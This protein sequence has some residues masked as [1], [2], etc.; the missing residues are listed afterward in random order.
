MNGG[1]SAPSSLV[2]ALLTVR[3]CHAKWLPE[4]NG[5]LLSGKATWNWRESIVS[6]R[7]LTFTALLL[8]SVLGLPLAGRLRS[9]PMPLIAPPPYV[10]A[11]RTLNEA[12][13][14]LGEWLPPQE[15]EQVRTL[16]ER[17]MVLRYYR[18]LGQGIRNSWGLWSGGSG[19]SSQLCAMGMRDAEMMSV[20]VLQSFW[21]RVHS[22]PLRVEEQV[23]QMTEAEAKMISDWRA[24]H[25]GELAIRPSGCPV[26]DWIE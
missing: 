4:A 20:V 10:G 2:K 25:P 22:Q 5:S 17:E 26:R 3:A 12:L 19:I 8:A 1:S 16:S 13:D 9:V 6:T 14:L 11:P 7:R 15:L 23:R 18:G 21:R 24:A